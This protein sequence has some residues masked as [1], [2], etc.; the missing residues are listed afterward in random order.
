MRSI[1]DSNIPEFSKSVCKRD[2]VCL[3]SWNNLECHATHVVAQ[4]N[5][6]F[7]YDEES[8]FQR[9]G[10]HSKHQVQNGLFLCAVCHGQFD[11]LKR[12]VDVVEENGD[13]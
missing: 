6:P 7:N 2:G 9:V 1:N 13:V 4:K 3:F 8:I 12:Y 11:K 10:L 5:L